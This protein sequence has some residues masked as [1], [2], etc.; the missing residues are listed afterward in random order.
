MSLRLSVEDQRSL[1]R[2]R[3]AMRATGI[4]P[5]LRDA[6]L[7][8]RAGVTVGQLEDLL[9][10]VTTNRPAW[11]VV[12]LDDGRRTVAPAHGSRPSLGGTVLAWDAS[13]VRRCPIT[14]TGPTLAREHV[15]P[16]C[17]HYGVPVAAAGAA[18]SSLRQ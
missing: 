14:L 15:V 8:D 6:P 11:L 13:A 5:A 16:V 18:L 3:E 7:R 9:A 1:K 17:R 10:D 2:N 12:R 4:V